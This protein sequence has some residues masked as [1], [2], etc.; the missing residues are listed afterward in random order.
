MRQKK[1][2]WGKPSFIYARNWSKAKWRRPLKRLSKDISQE[3]DLVSWSFSTAL[4]SNQRTQAQSEC[5]MKAVLQIRPKIAT[6][7]KLNRSLVNKIFKHFASYWK[8]TNGSFDAER[9]WR[10]A[11]NLG[12]GTTQATLQPEKN[13]AGIHLWRSCYK[14]WKKFMALGVINAHNCI[15]MHD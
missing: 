3:L 7:K 1:R 4:L 15:I 14:N 2:Y 11:E 8:K 5:M 12:A 9:F 6:L 13:F 10:I